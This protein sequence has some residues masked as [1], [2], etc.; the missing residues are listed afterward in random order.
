[1][2]MY[3][4]PPPWG[5]GPTTPPPQA[6]D[7]WEKALKFFEKLERKKL[8]KEEDEKKKKKEKGPEGP[9]AFQMFVFLTAVT[10][11]VGPATVWATA[12]MM[13]QAFQNLQ[14]IVPH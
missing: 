3:N 11:F 6:T 13:R 7:S 9:S 5:Y 2:F 12:F 10:P 8:K 4:M 14:A 1:M